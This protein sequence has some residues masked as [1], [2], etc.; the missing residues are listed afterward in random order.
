[1]SDGKAC[2]R[3]VGDLCR[4]A[5]EC[6]SRICSVHN[7]GTM[8]CAPAP[9]CH[10]GCESCRVAGDCCSANCVRDADGTSHCRSGACVAEGELCTT[11]ENCCQ[12]DLALDCVQELSSPAVKRCRRS[13]T[14]AC[15]PE[16]ERCALGTLCCSGRCVQTDAGA[17][18]HCAF[19]CSFEGERCT[20]RADCCSVTADCVNVA[21]RQICSGT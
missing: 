2:T 13:S 10:T 11:K 4:N 5:D 17:E 12:T 8:R 16:G 14:A 6:C 18:F 1:M 7:D 9:A 15:L 19:A 3:Q 21:G 20:S